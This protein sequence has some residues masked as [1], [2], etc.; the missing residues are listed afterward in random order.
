M[1]KEIDKVDGVQDRSSKRIDIR[2]ED[3]TEQDQEQSTGVIDA[4]GEG[5]TSIGYQIDR[6]KQLKILRRSSKITI[7]DIPIV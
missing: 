5:G 2:D 7:R 6:M 4:T 1:L 3:I